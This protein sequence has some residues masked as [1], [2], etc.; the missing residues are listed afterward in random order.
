M[1]GTT[2]AKPLYLLEL[3]AGF[4]SGEQVLDTL[5]KV[6]INWNFTWSISGSSSNMVKLFTLSSAENFNKFISIFAARIPKH[7]IATNVASLSELEFNIY[8]PIVIF[9]YNP[10]LNWLHSQPSSFSLATN[11]S[12]TSSINFCRHSLQ[13]TWT[14][15]CFLNR[16]LF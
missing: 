10:F 15:T 3:A 16:Y 9:M 8:K 6:N 12:L 2:L 4:L 14:S 13:V 1:L 7:N 5:Q 11:Y